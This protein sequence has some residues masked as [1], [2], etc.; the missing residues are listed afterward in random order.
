VYM[1]VSEYEFLCIYIHVMM[2]I[3][4]I[5]IFLIYLAKKEKIRRQ[6]HSLFR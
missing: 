4:C 1:Y 3:F 2:Y 6:M 5:Y